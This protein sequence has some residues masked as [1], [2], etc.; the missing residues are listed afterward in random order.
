MHILFVYSWIFGIIEDIVRCPLT[1]SLSG[2]SFHSNGS[3]SCRRFK[4]VPLRNLKYKSSLGFMCSK[5]LSVQICFHVCSYN[6]FSDAVFTQT[7]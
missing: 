6:S 7:I 1:A 2:W 3:E 4:M 5:V